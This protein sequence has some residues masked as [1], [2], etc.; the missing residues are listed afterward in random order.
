MRKKPLT[1]GDLSDA[2]GCFWNAA[3]GDAHA[4][5][6]G[7]VFASIMATGIAAVQQRLS[8]IEAAKTTAASQEDERHSSN[9]KHLLEMA[10]QMG[11]PDDGEGA[12]NFITRKAYEQGKEDAK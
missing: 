7:H 10:R 5:Q 3:I 9:G 6:E 1:A 8:E 4:Q 11:W 12:F 2:L